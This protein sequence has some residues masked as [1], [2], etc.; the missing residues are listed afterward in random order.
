[1]A[2]I[3]CSVSVSGWVT[4]WVWAARSN[5]TA[6]SAWRSTFPFAVRGSLSIRTNADG[7]M[8]CGKRA[9]R[10]LRSEA[11]VRTSPSGANSA[12]TYASG[13]WCRT[14]PPRSAEDRIAYT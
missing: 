7:I 14:R 9:C 11:G 2:A 12:G 13:G 10:C 6:A 5:E 1:M 3:A 8:Y 4:S